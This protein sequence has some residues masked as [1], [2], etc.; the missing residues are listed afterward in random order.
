[1]VR[2]IHKISGLLTA[3]A[4]CG[5]G[6]RNER[7]GAPTVWQRRYRMARYYECCYGPQRLCY[8]ADELGPQRK[9]LRAMPTPSEGLSSVP[10]LLLRQ[11]LVPGSKPPSKCLDI[12]LYHIIFPM[13]P[14]Y[15]NPRDGIMYPA[16]GSKSPTCVPQ[17][18]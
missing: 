4:I 3:F 16:F 6:H 8:G 18:D 17:N 10:P 12:C 1:M 5:A 15:S 7:P 13:S 11:C 2:D 9:L 14:W